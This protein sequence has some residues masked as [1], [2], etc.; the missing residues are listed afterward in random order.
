M[1][2]LYGGTH[3]ECKK[4]KNSRWSNIETEP[5]IKAK[6]DSDCTGG[7]DFR[8]QNAA[9]KALKAGLFDAGMEGLSASI[10]WGGTNVE[11]QKVRDRRCT[12]RVQVAGGRGWG[13]K[14]YC[15]V[16]S[17]EQKKPMR[18]N[19]A[20]KVVKEAVQSGNVGVFWNQISRDKLWIAKKRGIW[21][22]LV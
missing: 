21:K 16:V 8:S 18:K 6:Q 22:V 4:A 5:V 1:R 17:G 9:K 14:P 20:L 19:P 2:A 7:H 3:A 11:L 12:C 10:L 13:H 15:T